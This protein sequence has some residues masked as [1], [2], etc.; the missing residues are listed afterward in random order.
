[1]L[2]ILTNCVD[3]AKSLI[4]NVPTLTMLTL[5]FCSLT[6]PWFGSFLGDKVNTIDIALRNKKKKRQVSVLHFIL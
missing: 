3:K 2:G 1:M 5:K 6:V 4:P